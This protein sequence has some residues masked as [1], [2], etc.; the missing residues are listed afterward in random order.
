MAEGDPK[1]I[2]NAKLIE[3]IEGMPCRVID[4]PESHTPRVIPRWPHHDSEM[5]QRI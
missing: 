2:T 4:D 1:P 3:A 5:H